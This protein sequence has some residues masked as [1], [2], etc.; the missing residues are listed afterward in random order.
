MIVD[1]FVLRRVSLPLR[2]GVDGDFSLKQLLADRAG[3]GIE[4]YARHSNPRFAQILKILGFDRP[5]ARAEGAY[6][7]DRQGTRFLDWLGGFGMYNVGRNNPAVRRALE[8]LLALET[9]SLPQLGLS[10]LP[11]LL[12]EALVRV[13]PPSTDRVVFVNTGTEAV[14]AAVKLARAPAGGRASLPSGTA[15]TASRWARSR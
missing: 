7:Y 11:G 10:D 8:E 9:P 2:R 1:R 15:S 14:E 12:A 6:L 3:E 4:L 5:W 13:A